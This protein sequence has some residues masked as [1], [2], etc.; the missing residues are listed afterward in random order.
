MQ[1]ESQSD[2]WP[3][4]EA[5]Y[6]E[7]V[8]QKIPFPDAMTL[9]TVGGDGK[10]RARVVLY[11]GRIDDGLTFYTN[12]ES[13]KGLE[14]ARVPHA[15]LVFHW[16]VLEK[17]VRIEGAVEKLSAEQSD[18]YFATRP[19][20]SQLGAWASAQSEVLESREVLDES[21][22]RFEQEYAGQEVPRPPHWGGYRVIPS[23]FEFWMGHAGR[24]NDRVLFTSTD[25]TWKRTRL[26][27]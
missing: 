17:Q 26:A 5:W 27:P 6:Q 19:R 1:P 24:L 16:A 3:V 10:P 2:P 12:Y 11:K 15:A 14:L 18:R 7:A 4:F 20:E 25:G 23:S 9:A 22:H 21:Y 8:E 13:Y